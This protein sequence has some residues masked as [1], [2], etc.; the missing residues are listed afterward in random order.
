MNINKNGET[1]IADNQI[2]TIGGSVLA[3]GNSDYC[4][5]CGRITEVRDG[6]DKETENE[7]PDIYCDFDIPDKDHMI[8]EIETRF[9]KLYQTPKCIDELPL[10]GVIMAPEM[11]E[12]VADTLPDS[13]GKLYVLLYT[14]DGECDNTLS[15]LAVSTDRSVLMRKMFDD[16]DKFE[17]KEGYKAVLSHTSEYDNRACF[18]FEPAAVEE[19]SFTLDYSIFEVPAYG[20]VEGGAA[21]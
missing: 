4:G 7:G 17:E 10:D 2:F 18:T 1:F 20:A 3:N 21:A 11:L 15:V 9:S 14:Y 12:P 19:S 8:A 6:D 5:L 13:M 16:L